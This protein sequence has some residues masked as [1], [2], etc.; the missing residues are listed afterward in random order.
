MT[1]TASPQ[2]DNGVAVEQLLGAREAFGQTP[3]AG[4]FTWKAA[5]KWV[6]G[7][8]TNT[9]VSNFFGLGEEQSH[10]TAHSIV[11]D[12][13]AIFGATDN[14]ASPPEL[15]LMGLAGCLSAGIASVAQN[16]GIKLHSVNATVE[17]DMDLAGILGVDA[18][19]RNGFSAIRVRYEIDADADR[20]DIEAVVAQSQK[21]SAVYDVIANPTMVAVEVA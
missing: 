21:R 19:V 14:G 2:A 6:N 11:T 4:Q 16:R 8:E 15:M 18:D 13:P 1:T 17:G 10:P 7:S 9:T 12:H 20:T 3:A 5:S